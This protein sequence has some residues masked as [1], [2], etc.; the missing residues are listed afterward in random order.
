MGING[1]YTSGDDG[2]IDIN[3]GADGVGGND[4]R[5]NDCADVC[6]S[7]CNKCRSFVNGM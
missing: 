5:E 2:D 7:D 1:L 4:D 6:V 3:E